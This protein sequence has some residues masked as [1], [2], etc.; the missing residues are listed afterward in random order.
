M[1]LATAGKVAVQLCNENDELVWKAYL[2]NQLIAECHKEDWDVIE[3]DFTTKR[4]G[5]MLA[6]AYNEIFASAELDE[7]ASMI[8][9]DDGEV[10]NESGPDTKETGC[11][12]QCDKPDG[13]EPCGSESEPES[14]IIVL[15]L[16]D[17]LNQAS[18]AQKAGKPFNHLLIEADL[19]AKHLNE[20]N[21][22]SLM[23]QIDTLMYQAE[24]ELSEG[25]DC[26]ATLN[27]V[28]KLMI[29]TADVDEYENDFDKQKEDE[30]KEEKKLDEEMPHTASRA[31]F[32]A[33][34]FTKLADL[35]K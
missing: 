19:W 10:E 21:K 4:A 26:E 13:H 7:D 25:L 30:K 2:K 23:A 24:A 22:V 29:I 32:L 11:C 20:L 18:A 9:T 3:T 14:K 5:Q 31:N 12:G 27:K 35:V 8:K 34:F 17:L 1:L 28:A 15:K 6:D 33:R 16:N